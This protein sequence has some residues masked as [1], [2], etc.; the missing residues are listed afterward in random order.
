M[1]GGAAPAAGSSSA[2]AAGGSHLV[3]AGGSQAGL[4][5]QASLSSGG[6]FDLTKAISGLFD[7]MGKT[8]DA[9][10]SGAQAQTNQALNDQALNPAD[11]PWAGYNT[12][13]PAT[14][15]STGWK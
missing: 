12:S 3:V 7:W 6:T 10:T 13:A 1:P 9:W 11:S 4:P 14:A 8:Y 15:T 5:F 2:T